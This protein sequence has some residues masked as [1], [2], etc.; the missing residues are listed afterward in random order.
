[1]SKSYLGTLSLITSFLITLCAVFIIPD[2]I[3]AL[4]FPSVKIFLT[5]FL[6]RIS[7][8]NVLIFTAFAGI[9]VFNILLKCLNIAICKKFSNAIVFLLDIAFIACSVLVLLFCPSEIFLFVIML[10]VLAIL[11][12][13]VYF[14]AEM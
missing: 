13:F 4:G 7:E 14:Y 12:D 9:L 6:S 5:D 10:S 2:A 8:F 11:F 3:S 1:M